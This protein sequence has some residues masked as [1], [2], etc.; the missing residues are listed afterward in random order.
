MYKAFFLA[1]SVLY[2]VKTFYQ[3][4]LKMKLRTLGLFCS[5][6]CFVCFESLIIDASSNPLDSLLNRKIS[7]NVWSKYRVTYHKGKESGVK[8]KSSIIDFNIS[9]VIEESPTS[10]L[11]VLTGAEVQKIVDEEASEINWEDL[12]DQELPVKIDF[13]KEIHLKSFKNTIST[14]FSSNPIQMEMFIK[15][16]S[17]KNRDPSG[18]KPISSSVLALQVFKKNDR[19]VGDQ[20]IPVFPTKEEIGEIL[21]IR[22]T[23]KIDTIRRGFASMAASFIYQ[24]NLPFYLAQ[25]KIDFKERYQAADPIG[26]LQQLMTLIDQRITNENSD[27]YSV[28]GARKVVI[29]PED[30]I[31]YTHFIHSEGLD[32][33]GGSPGPVGA[34]QSSGHGSVN[35]ETPESPIC[36]LMRTGKMKF[37]WGK[38]PAHDEFM[39]IRMGGVLFQN[40][41]LITKSNLNDLQLV[42]I[43]KPVTIRY[44]FDHYD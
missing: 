41:E 8:F 24:E 37:K 38:H 3:R 34:E 20:V 31:W 33:L 13:V 36:E 25:L 12:R 28:L 15:S 14:L 26:S 17:I 6:I 22:L 32:A 9:K 18:H 10:L 7:L 23:N 39:G 1:Y 4:M 21:K 42:L 5:F 11:V 16:S 35:A 40:G 43:G 44:N 29:K 30:V 2:H 19:K 27:D